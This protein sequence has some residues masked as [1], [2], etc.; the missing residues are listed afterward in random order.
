MND[1]FHNEDTDAI[2]YANILRK[3][4]HHIM[5][6]NEFE[7]VTFVKENNDRDHQIGKYFVILLHFC[8]WFVV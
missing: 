2:L 8:K 7:D 4:I 6:E 5:S 1:S 3:V